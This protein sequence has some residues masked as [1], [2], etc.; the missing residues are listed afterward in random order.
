LSAALEAVAGV[1]FL[2]AG[3][4][5]WRSREPGAGAAARAFSGWWS[6]AGSY[7]IVSSAFDVAAAVGGVPFPFFLAG[8]LLQVATGSLSLACLAYY[9]VFLF[10][11]KRSWVIPVVTLYVVTGLLGLVAA[12]R[13]HPYAIA[14]T[15][16][17]ADLAY[18]LPFDPASVAVVSVL[19]LP[20]VLGGLA[21]ASLSRWVEAPEAKRRMVLVGLAM[22]AWF[23]GALAAEVVKD[24]FWQFVTRSG[25]GIVVAGIVLAAYARHKLPIASAS[26]A[27]PARAARSA[28]HGSRE[29]ELAGRVR[30]LV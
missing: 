22:A 16:W 9:L 13:R 17:R 28:A 6:L 18:A 4:V 30:E 10:T 3:R 29:H 25:V 26:H 15:S 21:Y 12:W 27:D 11:G 1:A 19:L 24:P 14:A 5:F 8:K 2:Y 23:S 7:D 20:P